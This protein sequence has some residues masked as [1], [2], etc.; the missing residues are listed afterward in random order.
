AL[1]AGH[2]KHVHDPFTVPHA[3]EQSGGG[4]QIDSQTAYEQLVG[5]D[6][7]QF[8]H[9]YPDIFSPF[10]NFYARQFFHRLYVTYNR[11]MG[12]QVIQPGSVG[13]K[14]GIGS[15]F[16]NFFYRTM[17]IAHVGYSINHY[18]SV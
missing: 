4:S 11:Q 12:A 9:N 17:H 3:V 18:F 5:S 13:Y 2:F 16:S 1:P 15:A 10:R 6:T 14:L 7:G 8:S